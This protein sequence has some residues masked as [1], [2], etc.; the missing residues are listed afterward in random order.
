LLLVIGRFVK[1]GIANKNPQ[2]KR[3]GEVQETK[4]GSR[5]RGKVGKEWRRRFSLK[6]PFNLLDR[7]P[8][9]CCLA[10]FFWGLFEPSHKPSLCLFGI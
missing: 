9:D 10:F 1:V 5:E 8:W 6:A 7:R 4:G 2:K 3:N